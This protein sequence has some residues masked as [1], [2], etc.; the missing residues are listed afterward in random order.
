[1]TRL[2]VLTGRLL[3]SSYYLH[4]KVTTVNSRATNENIINRILNTAVLFCVAGLAARDSFFS[5]VG[6]ALPDRLWRIGLLALFG[7]TARPGL[8]AR[9]GLA[10]ADLG[11][12][13]VDTG[14]D[15]EPRESDNFDRNIR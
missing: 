2:S 4:D 7:L 13:M 8:T 11:R 10:E 1:M 6:V 15:D 5:R 12:F 14:L 3:T 9:L